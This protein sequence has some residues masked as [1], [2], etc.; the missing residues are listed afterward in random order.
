M[1]LTFVLRLLGRPT[2]DDPHAVAGRLEVVRSGEEHVVHSIDEV[3]D[4]LRHHV[5]LCRPST[6]TNVRTQEQPQ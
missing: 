3:A 1:T 5:E 2:A 6:R 4:V